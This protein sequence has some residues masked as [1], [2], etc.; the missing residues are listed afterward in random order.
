MKKSNSSILTK[1]IFQHS[2]HINLFNRKVHY[3]HH[4]GED[5]SQSGA[6]H[7]LYLSLFEHSST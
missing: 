1:S 2:E 6:L 7:F 4:I 3:H 5:D